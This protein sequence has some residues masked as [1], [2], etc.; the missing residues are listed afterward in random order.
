MFHV[1]IHIFSNLQIGYM[2]VKYTGFSSASATLA[3]IMIVFGWSFFLFVSFLFVIKSNSLLI[4]AVKTIWMKF[5]I[6]NLLFLNFFDYRKRTC[7]VIWKKGK[8]QNK[9][10]SIK[11]FSSQ[12]PKTI[13]YFSFLIVYLYAFDDHDLQKKKSV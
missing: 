2:T 8:K 4:F 10:A 12:N 9:Y 13:R 1:Y 7:Q 11:L 5:C 6:W 3:A